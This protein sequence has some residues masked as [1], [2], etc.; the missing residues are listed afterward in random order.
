MKPKGSRYR[1]GNL[2]LIEKYIGTA[3]NV[4]NDVHNHLKEIDIPDIALDKDIIQ[5]GN[6]A[7][8]ILPRKYINKAATVVIKKDHKSEYRFYKAIKMIVTFMHT[9]SCPTCKKLSKNM[10][11]K[12]S[13]KKPNKINVE[14]KCPDCNKTVKK[15]LVSPMD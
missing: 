13:Y 2:D 6:S 9:Y 7:H 14:A 15:A 11:W 10:K 4:L 3:H 1:V 5:F 12:W 8:I